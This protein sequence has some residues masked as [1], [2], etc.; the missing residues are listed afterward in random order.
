MINTK[1]I[2]SILDNILYR[3]SRNITFNII[4]NNLLVLSFHNIYSKKSEIDLD[5]LHPQQFITVGDFR[6]I[7]NILIQ[8]NFVFIDEKFD[9]NR[10][11][12]VKKC[13]LTFDDGYRNN[14]LILNLLK[15]FRI[16]A[17]FFVVPYNIESGE[18]FWWDVVYRKCKFKGM[19]DA[20][21]TK[22]IE[23]VKCIHPYKIRDYLY[24]NGISDLDFLPKSDIDRPLT[25]NELNF[26]YDSKYINLGNHT[27]SHEILTLLNSDELIY[28]I[29]QSNIYL[30]SITKKNITCIAY[31]NGCYNESVI[32]NILKLGL[33]WGFS[34]DCI[35][36]QYNKLDL[37]NLKLG[38][39]LIWGILN[40]E[41]Q[42]QIF[43]LKY[44]FQNIIQI[45][46]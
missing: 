21:I 44:S 5:L 8:H 2:I 4:D 7:L 41:K 3:I 17:I 33:L 31:P 28:S 32:S 35:T 11:D 13:L 29:N 40:I 24:K 45:M 19:S 10:N 34:L 20:K 6:L 22:Y 46:R 16:K 1:N 26:A 15:E 38:R 37:R 9:C 39:K 42:I 12:Y 36:N 25:R 30:Q 23:H 18:C 14:L 43:S 27:W